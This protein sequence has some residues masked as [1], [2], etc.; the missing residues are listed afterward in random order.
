MQLARRGL[1]IGGVADGAH[2]HDP[3]RSGG[4]DLGHVRGVD[5]TDRKPGDAA[6]GRARMADQVEPRGGTTFLG[7]RLPDRP[8]A[9]LVGPGI[10]GR[11]ER[12][13]EL[14]RRMRG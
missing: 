2:H 9:E 1:G 8:G 4:R 12:S 5:A 6:A 13:V 3:G 7:G 11:A 10:A 14:L